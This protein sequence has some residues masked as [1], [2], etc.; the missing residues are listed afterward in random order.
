M[1]GDDAIERLP[2]PLRT[3]EVARAMFS[4]S[5]ILLAGGGAAIAILSGAWVLAPFAAAGAWAARVA[6]AAPW[7]RGKRPAIKP[8]KLPEPW[9]GFV[10]DAARA[11]QRFDELIRQVPAGPLQDELR[12][13]GRRVADGVQECQQVAQ[14]GVMLDQARKS[15]QLGLVTNELQRLHGER[16]LRAQQG[17]DVSTLDQAIAAT[18]RQ[19][20][21][22]QRV[23]AVAFQTRDRLRVLNAQLDEATAAVIELTVRPGATSA[24]A[25]S[26]QVEGIVDQLTS[27]RV[28]LDEA[29]AITPTSTISSSSTLETR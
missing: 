11:Q 14:K 6:I 21:A 17:M 12:S 15:L 24:G 29:S 4:P 1:D 19:L 9:R 20:D 25:L 10:I 16:S 7:G 28:A 23:E 26:G 27:L 5:A 22:G 13:I 18:Q 3:P 2:S 8:G